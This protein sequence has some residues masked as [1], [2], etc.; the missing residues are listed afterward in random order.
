M[1]ARGHGEG[2]PD[3]SGAERGPLFD[4]ASSWIQQRK[5]RSSN[6]EHTVY[7]EGMTEDAHSALETTHWRIARSRTLMDV[8]NCYLSLTRVIAPKIVQ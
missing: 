2:I 8:R 3:R 6:H 4:A 5:K 1:Y 7:Q